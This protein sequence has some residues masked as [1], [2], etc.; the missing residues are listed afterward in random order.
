MTARELAI[1]TIG[2]RSFAIIAKNAGEEAA[3]RAAWHRM[4][5]EQHQERARWQRARE[6]E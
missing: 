6:H 5:A 4:L 2:L 1:A 3:I